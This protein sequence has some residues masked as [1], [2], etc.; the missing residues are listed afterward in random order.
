MVFAFF[1]RFAGFFLDEI[2][3]I[4]WFLH[5]FRFFFFFFFSIVAVV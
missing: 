4:V 2:F 1:L 3:L 5:S